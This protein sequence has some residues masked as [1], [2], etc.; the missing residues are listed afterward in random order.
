[1]KCPVV[2]FTKRSQTYEGWVN[3]SSSLWLV[4]ERGAVG[5]VPPTQTVVAYN[6]LSCPAYPA[7]GHFE[8]TGGLYFET[9]PNLRRVGKLAKQRVVGRGVNEGRRA[10]PTLRKPL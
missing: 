3:W 5:G 8:K 10:V 7:L 6:E 4:K 1:M 9:K 2:R